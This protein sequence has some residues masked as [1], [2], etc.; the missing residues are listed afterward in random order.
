MKRL[1]LLF[2]VAALLCCTAPTKQV[3]SVDDRTPPV[4]DSGGITIP[5]TIDEP[6]SE[7]LTDE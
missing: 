4:T 6:N 3:D 7:A 2:A 5:D 1:V